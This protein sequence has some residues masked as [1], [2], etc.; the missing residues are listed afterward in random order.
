MFFYHVF[1]SDEPGSDYDNET[2]AE[3]KVRKCRRKAIKSSKEHLHLKCEWRQCDYESENLDN[4][5]LHVSHH[6]PH[7]RLRFNEENEGIIR[8]VKYFLGLVSSGHFHGICTRV[9]SWEFFAVT[10]STGWG[11][12]VPVT[13][14]RRN[15]DQ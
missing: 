15:I 1:A 4:F 3:T 2:V 9:E 8:A 10:I 11:S 6:I 5:V 7:L 14:L 12:H 13:S